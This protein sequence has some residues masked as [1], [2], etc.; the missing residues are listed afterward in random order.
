MKPGELHLAGLAIDSDPTLAT[1]A[2]PWLD[3]SEL[4]TV[5][6]ES[7][8]GLFGTIVLPEPVSRGALLQ[9]SAR[10]LPELHLPRVRPTNLRHPPAE[11]DK[12]LWKHHGSRQLS[13]TK[14]NQL[15]AG[16]SRQGEALLPGD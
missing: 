14:Q 15:Q 4:T 8:Q 9:E 2:L 16:C 10:V 5:T 1:R 11:K 7:R 13:K 3:D 6:L 12:R